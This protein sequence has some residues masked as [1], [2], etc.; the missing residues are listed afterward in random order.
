MEKDGGGSITMQVFFDRLNAIA[1]TPDLSPFKQT[2][3]QDLS[4]YA[5]SIYPIE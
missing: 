2:M 5:Q 4:D 1:Q 3:L